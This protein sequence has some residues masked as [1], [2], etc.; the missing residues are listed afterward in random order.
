MRYR[1]LEI[2]AA[3]LVVQCGGETVPPPCSGAIASAYADISAGQGVGSGYGSRAVIDGLDDRLLVM[4]AGSLVACNPDGSHCVATP[5]SQQLGAVPP[6]VDEENARLLLFDGSSVAG[7]IRCNLDGSG[8]ALTDIS[9]GQGTFPTSAV[10]D[11]VSRKLLVVTANNGLLRCNLDGTGCTFTDISLGHGTLSMYA[12]STVIDRANGKLLVVTEDGD[13]FHKSALFRCN[14]DGTGCTYTDISAGQ[15]PLSGAT[16]SAVIDTVNGKLLVVTDDQ[17]MTGTATLPSPSLFLCDLDGTGC[18]YTDISA[19]GGASSGTTPLAFI[20]TVNGKLVV[21]AN[22]GPTLIQCGLD[23]TGCVYTDVSSAQ[24]LSLGNAAMDR[25]HDALLI[26]GTTPWIT[27]QTGGE[28]GLL[29]V[30]LCLP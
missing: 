6:L 3:L 5:V 2:V 28:A 24:I 15:P 16:P 26:V 27:A 23:G 11:G 30:S 13:N 12:P 25:A 18:T 8:C 22:D 21:V 19:G 20:D 10:I 4:E 29:T 9:V 1:R 14:L 17:A 7:L